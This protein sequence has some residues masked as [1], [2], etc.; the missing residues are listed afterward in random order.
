[1]SPI[2]TQN[3]TNT[4]GIYLRKYEYLPVALIDMINERIINNKNI[5]DYR[6]K[7]NLIKCISLI[8]IK[9]I[10]E[11]GINAFVPVGRSY[12]KKIFGGEYKQK[13]IQP[14]IE[15]DII[16]PFDYGNRFFNNKENPD[17]KGQVSIR[18]RV[19]PDLINDHYDII[20]YLGKTLTAKE[21]ELTKGQ[22][23]IE[24]KSIANDS[25]FI[26]IMR[27]RAGE[28]V[29][30][31][32]IDICHNEFYNKEFP[33][34]L[35]SN[36]KIQY[37]E[38]LV[39]EN[40]HT[41]DWH[42]GTIEAAKKHAY[43]MGKELFFFRDKFYVAE[44]EIFLE[45]RIAA[46]KHHYNREI[47]KVGVLPIENNRS[48]L[49][50]RVYNYLTNF[51]SKLLPFLT[52][53]NN[54]VH[55]IDLRTSQALLFSNII[56]IYLNKTWEPLQFGDDK[57]KGEKHLLYLFKRSQTRKYLRRLFEILKKYHKVLPSHGFDIEHDSHIHLS[58]DDND[59]LH[60]I[61]NVFYDDLYEVLKL[62]LDL[63]NRDAAKLVMFKILFGKGGRR[64]VYMDKFKM[65]YP[66]IMQIISDF[67]SE[68]DKNK[69]KKSQDSNFSVFLQCVESEI[70]ID[71]IYKPL[72][73]QGIDCFS[74]HDSIVVVSGQEITVKNFIKNVFKE[75]EFVYNYK[76]EDKLFEAYTDE[77]LQMEFDLF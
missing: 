12:W 52:I 9:Q 26:G 75:I 2:N 63:P 43:R 46:M 30:K 27:E 15:L 24:E 14:I 5:R 47:A 51:P 44:P 11:Y 33:N 64:D 10:K 65:H 22:G 53:N 37:H 35:P 8:F 60:F 71:R 31:E 72:R 25:L 36:F 3:K 32:L 62:Q 54:T 13:V 6:Q 67:K 45:R 69:K 39:I 28:F 29:D 58:G 68:D 40:Q 1:M 16:D 17:K 49:T 77:E 34:Q 23:F 19:R 21:E 66:T 48:P 20:H 56:N 7:N 76:E 57:D 38:H 55:Q 70:F 42:H 61:K 18:Y 41:F 50:L 73:K 4:K 59:M 74:R